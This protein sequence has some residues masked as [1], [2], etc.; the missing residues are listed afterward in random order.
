MYVLVGD[1]IFQVVWLEAWC[2]TCSVP[3]TAAHYIAL[4]TGFLI[5][6]Q[7]LLSVHN[8]YKE[9][10]GRFTPAQAWHL[11]GLDTFNVKACFLLKN[12]AGASI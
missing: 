3:Q 7:F 2:L 4:I 5:A 9:R 11:D 8:L 10:Q 1:H 12:T 6:H